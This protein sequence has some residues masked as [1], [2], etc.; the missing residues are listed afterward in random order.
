M[1]GVRAS[2]SKCTEQLSFNAVGDVNAGF[3]RQITP[4]IPDILIGFRRK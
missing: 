4:D 3:L 1:P 2:I